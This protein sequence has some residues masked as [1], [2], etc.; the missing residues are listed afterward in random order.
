MQV[1]PIKEADQLFEVWPY[2]L[3]FINTKEK[4]NWL[5]FPWKNMY[6]VKFTLSI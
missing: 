3:K 5:N 2:T 1:L 6:F 4:I